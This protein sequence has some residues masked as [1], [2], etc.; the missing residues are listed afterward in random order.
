MNITRHTKYIWEV[1]NLITEEECDEFNNLFDN[2]GLEPVEGFRNL[3]RKNDS[4]SFEDQTAQ[5]VDNLAWS[6][7]LRAHKL[8]L[9]K[10]Q[11]IFF[12]W[13]KEE[14]TG[15][16]AWKGKNIIR[17]YNA[18]DFY[19]WHTD[20]NKTN[21][22]ELSYII[23]L[24]DDFEG[25]ETCFKNDDLSVQPKKCSA[26]C[27]P[28]DHYHIHRSNKIISGNKRIIWNCLFRSELKVSERTTGYGSIV[29]A[30]RGSKRSIW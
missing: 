14:L 7:V 28:V 22:S 21:L 25:G 13:D 29:G 6:F 1:E 2:L 5:E 12:N 23:Y 24:N 17:S 4:Y 11:W 20:H 9:E 27:F 26:L 3:V 15:D 8:F 16:T 30:P 18:D 19:D 10:N